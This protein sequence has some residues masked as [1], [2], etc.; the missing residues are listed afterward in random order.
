MTEA[1]RL[2]A[3]LLGVL[4]SVVAGGQLTGRQ[5]ME[6]ARQ[7]NQPDDETVVAEMTLAQE[8]GRKV[9]RVFRLEYLRG[10]DGL[11][12]MLIRFFYPRRMKGTGLLT[13]ERKGRPDDQWL[14]LPSLRRIRRI[15]TNAR[16]ERFVQSDFT[17]EDLQPEDLD[18][19]DYELLGTAEVDG[20]KCYLVKARPKSQSAYA[21]REIAVDCER[22]LPLQTKYF[23]SDGKCV[24]TQKASG[25][26]QHAGRYWRA[27][28]I[29]MKDHQRRH[30]TV[31][32]IKERAIN[33]G[34]PA[35]HFTTR[36]LGEGK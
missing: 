24:K 27:D 10:D 25:V 22:W 12:R 9:R 34:V 13:I 36:F 33:T 29:E 26:R 14:Y 7:V 15:A 32:S 20:R 6:K 1:A 18:D 28:R 19:N 8:G 30:S 3:A 17:Y 11:D 5:V 35:S 21:W 31:L 16:T 2:G 4:C 23:A